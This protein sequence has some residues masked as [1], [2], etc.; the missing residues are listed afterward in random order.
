[1][2]KKPKVVWV[3]NIPV[4]PITAKERRELEQRIKK[5]YERYRKRYKE[6][7]GKVVDWIYHNFEQD[8]LY[9][10]IRFKDKTY[11]SLSFSPQIVTE[12][13]EFSDMTSG[14]DEI[15]RSYYRRRDDR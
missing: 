5:R 3:G 14:D 13:I 8:T 4:T 10:G 12:G 11:F 2:P 1:M 9:V 6:V 15:I 7:H